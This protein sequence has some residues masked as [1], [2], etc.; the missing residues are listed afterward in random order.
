M[1]KRRFDRRDVLK[2][3]GTGLVG[4][5]GGAGGTSDV[6][7]DR[8]AAA[9]RELS[10]DN[11]LREDYWVAVEGQDSDNSGMDDRVHVEIARPESTDDPGVELPVVVE[12]SPYYGE[13][14]NAPTNAVEVE[15]WAPDGE[16]AA[17]SPGVGNPV[18]LTEDDLVEFTGQEA[19]IGPSP[20]EEE[21]LGEGYVWAYASSVGTGESSGCLDTGGEREVNGVEAVVDWFNGRATAY[22]EPTGGDPVEA[23]W[24][25][26]ET[27]MIGASY[28]G[29]LPIAAASRGIDDLETIVPEVAI[30]SWYDYY[31]MN[32]HVISP[33]EDPAE[34]LS[35]GG[36]T[37]WLQQVVVNDQN[38]CEH[39]TEELSEGQDRQTGDR[40]AFWAER[41]YLTEGET[42]DASVLVLHGL[43]DHNVKIRNAAEFVGT[44][45]EH[46]VPYSVW[47][48]QGGHTNP[49]EPGVAHE[50]E[51]LGLLSDWF[52]YWLKGEDN[53]VMD[54]PTARVQRGDPATGQLEPYE[55][56]PDPET[57]HA[58]LWCT[59]GGQQR[60]GLELTPSEAG[61]E[62]Q[63]QDLTF[64][65][66]G[67]T[68]AE[69]PE[70]A[71]VFT[72]VEEDE[73][74]HRLLY[75]TDPL[76][77]SVRL[78]GTPEASLRLSVDSEAAIV[79]VG[80][81]DYGPDDDP[82]LVNWGWANPHNRTTIAESEP[83]EAGEP[84]D[85]EFPVQAV[86]HVFE[87]GHRLGLVVYSTD[88]HFTLR[89]TS[90]DRT[91]T[92]AVDESG[93]SLP[94]VGGADA[95]AAALS[96]TDAQPVENWHDLDAV[97]DD[98]DGEYVLVA[99]L[100]SDSDGYDEHV[101]EP[102]S[103][104]E[105]IGEPDSEDS[106][107]GAFDGN[108]NEIADL[109][110]DRPQESNVGL[111]GVSDGVIEDVGVT[112][113]TVTGDFRVGGLLG[114]NFGKISESYATGDVTGEEGVGGLVGENFAGEISES[115]ATSDVTGEE[116][117]GGLVGGNIFAGEISESYAAGDATGEIRV[118]GLVGGNF[119]E[120]T[121]SFA[122]GEVDGDSAV[123]GVVGESE[124]DDT[125]VVD[126]YWDVEATGQQD[127][128]GDGEGDTTGLDTDEMQGET[129]AENMEALDFEATWTV[130]TDPDDYPV[131]QW[132][133]ETE[134]EIEDWHDLDAV[135]DDLDGEYVLVAGLDETTA[136]Y[137][138]HVEEPDGGWESIGT[139]TE[140]FTG[141]FDGDGHEIADLS[142]DRPE[143]AQV[144]LFGNLGGTIESVTVS[145]ATVTGQF[146]VGGLVG[147]LSDGDVAASSVT[148]TAITADAQVGG[149]VGLASFG[150]A[151]ADSSVSDVDIVGNSGVGGLAGIAGLGIALQNSF[152]DL[153]SVTL[154]SEQHLTT[155]GLFPEQYADWVDNDR[156]LDIDEYDSLT[157]VD[158]R[159]ELDGPQAVRDALGFVQDPERDWRVGVDLELT[160]DDAGLYLPYFAGTLDGDGHTV[161]VDLDLPAVADVGV[162]GDNRG[163]VFDLTASGTVTADQR[164]GGLVGRNEGE[165]SASSATG[166]TV[167][168]GFATGGLVGQLADGDI[169][170]STASQ[171]DITATTNAGG[172]VGQSF[173]DEIRES[174]VT[175]TD[176]DGTENVGGLVGATLDNGDVLDSSAT[177][178]GVTGETAVG[179]LVGAHGADGEIGESFAAGQVSGETDVGGL[180]GQLG[181]PF[182]E[183]GE[184]AILRDAYWDTETTGESDEV[185]AIVEGD[186]TAEI[187]GEV[188]GLATDQM[189]GEAAAE[190]MEA[191]DFEAT[192]VTRVGEGSDYP[193]LRWRVPPTVPGGEAPPQDLTDDGLFE[194]V[195]GDGEFTVVDVQALFDNLDSD[196]V[197]DNPE[198]FDFSS[199]DPDEVTIF[200]VQA[201]F[202]RL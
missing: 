89:P 133:I 73:N 177:A 13:F 14:N 155:G 18:G 103:G 47:F 147:Q 55:D 202:N 148:G 70:E 2:L 36:D 99:D 146:A 19:T 26:G 120:I 162:V 142:I 77:T 186:G 9:S 59:P 116:E 199:L 128:I 49:L 74:E 167:D 75:R 92:L 125:I 149:L 52:A 72:Y 179:T 143:S 37:D 194:D 157:E 166:V 158:G 56:W 6:I 121:S 136:G 91:L 108:G 182:L 60:G 97:R 192:W 33:A 50:D 76:E 90:D 197:Q 159:I 109:V 78:S 30:S 114:N 88:I 131:L 189:Q 7:R 198:A 53:G 175:E 35:F 20:Y 31:R 93:V 200:D 123:G 140:P 3:A 180:L 82:E 117:V 169:S 24:T 105:P 130:Q 161:T 132:Q 129:A 191:L 83:I 29:T 118:G 153:G 84:Y 127:G 62:E 15:L 17:G 134:I 187:Q 58:P 65:V 119:G 107:T 46:D 48:H 137:D 170:E 160:G 32:G 178:V 34:V 23:G 87:A 139:A 106:F 165:L 45:S 184:T 124:E 154:N 156:Q 44:L 138:E 135:R 1:S 39:V 111:F 64:L 112:D 144:G 69:T 181:A 51:W 110:I 80:L 115:Y 164:V 21:F 171:A 63:L 43:A 122:T 81:V 195:R 27:G 28:N 71:S 151:L 113:A 183:E 16:A 188:A 85:I 101:S 22:D 86:D 190:S 150:G 41:D 54:G 25:T 57:S 5:A 66:Q 4:A 12:P 163:A 96:E 79:S 185:G 201:L 40:N 68:G 172:L 98:L 196:A 11:V 152:Y 95:L 141:I 168:A 94:V 67:D 193:V 102:A 10:V 176:V 42:F 38:A 126:T 145:K 173:G 8:D 104:W 61:V 100:D 174:S